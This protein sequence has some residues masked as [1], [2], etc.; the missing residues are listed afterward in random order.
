[1]EHVYLRAYERC[2]DVDLDLFALSCI[3][4]IEVIWSEYSDKKTQ[5]HVHRLDPN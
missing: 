1:M 5:K 3:A 2:K 4:H